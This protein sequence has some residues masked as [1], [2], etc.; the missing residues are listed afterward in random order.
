MNER[1]RPQREREKRYQG[2]ETWE[3]EISGQACTWG[4][5]GP[6][7]QEAPICR[8]L[9]VEQGTLCLVAPLPPTGMP[10][11]YRQSGTETATL[12]QIQASPP[13]CRL[14]EL[15]RV[16][17][18]AVPFPQAGGLPEPRHKGPHRVQSRSTQL[19]R[20]LREPGR[21]VEA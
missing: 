14:P 4:Q 18:A 16:Q 6:G 11:S 9:W 13:P 12:C 21:W 10:L 5:T 7:G 15:P 3:K 17:S 20:L 8:G 2:G 1:V 19:H